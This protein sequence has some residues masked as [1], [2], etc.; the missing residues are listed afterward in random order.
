V[1]AE[2]EVR[3]SAQCC[4]GGGAGQDVTCG[5]LLAQQSESGRGY[6][7]LREARTRWRDPRPHLLE[8][9]RSGDTQWARFVKILLAVG[10]GRERVR[11]FEL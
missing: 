5:G 11:H 8:H 10:H 4:D 2:L 3:A 9:D 1:V 6:G 7:K